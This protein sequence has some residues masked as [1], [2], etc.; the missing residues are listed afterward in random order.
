MAGE[1]KLER[2]KQAAL[3]LFRSLDQGDLVSFVTFA[4]KV[5]IQLESEDA[6]NLTRLER[7]VNNLKP[8]GTT[9]L[10]DAL[11]TSNKIVG[12]AAQHQ[13]DMVNRI[14]LLTDGQPTKGKSKISDF[15]SLSHLIE[16]NNISVIA[17]GVGSDYNE[18]LL[19]SIATNSDGLW[20]HVTDPSD[21]TKIF[22]DQ[23]R[24]MKTVVM[25]KPK[26]TFTLMSGAEL[27]EVYK[28]RPMLNKLE[29]TQKSGNVHEISLTD[30]VGGKEQ[31]LVFGLTIPPRSPGEFRIAKAELTSGAQK[32]SE[33]IAITYTD[34]PALY[35][36]EADP[37]PRVLL[38]SSESTVL[39]R[40]GISMGDETRI[41]EAQTKIRSSLSNEEAQTVVRQNPLLSEIVTTFN[42]AVQETVIKKKLTETEKKELKS[43]TTVIRRS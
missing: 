28:V 38:S 2:A 29:G 13:P 40:K 22:S 4:S 18:D 32:F 41:R 33:N 21:I 20:Y 14:I 16:D 7:I 35:S 39:L 42:S 10:Y 25:T 23:L 26:L 27:S 17:I 1:M 30:I 9:A 31:N 8:A 36:K 19:T 15:V 43:K 3:H 11:G 34:D 6:V 24:D 37:Y 12:K 5:R